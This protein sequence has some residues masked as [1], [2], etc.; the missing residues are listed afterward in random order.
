MFLLVTNTHIFSNNIQCTY[1]LF[2]VLKWIVRL[3]NSWIAHAYILKEKVLH[4]PL[5]Y[6]GLRKALQQINK[7]YIFISQRHLRPSSLT[8][9]KFHKSQMNNA[10]ATWL[11]R[12]VPYLNSACK[13]QLIGTLHCDNRTVYITKAWGI[14]NAAT[15]KLTSWFLPFSVWWLFWL[16]LITSARTEGLLIFVNSHIRIARMTYTKL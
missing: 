15:L 4:G 2:D 9:I 10:N 14:K 12:Y 6:R 16:M 1:E 13:F 8:E 3:L 7:F 5:L 11:F